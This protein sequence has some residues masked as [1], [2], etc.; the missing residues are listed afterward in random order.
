MCLD[1][2]ELVVFLE[3]RGERC[4]KKKKTY[5]ELDSTA[6][7]KLVLHQS[8]QHHPYESSP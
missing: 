1:D 6:T 7:L 4:N 3:S 5:V 8:H 2:N